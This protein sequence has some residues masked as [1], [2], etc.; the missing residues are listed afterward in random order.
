MKNINRIK[1]L[2]KNECA[3]YFPHQGSINHYCCKAD[4]TCLF[5]KGDDK[6]RCSYFETGVLPID[7]KLEHEYRKEHEL[8]LRGITAKTKIKCQRCGEY[9]TANSNRQ[10]YCD[11]CRKINNREKAK[12]RMSRMR[13]KG[14]DVTI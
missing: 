11:K 7:E 14:Y 2:I 6:T 8:S 12:H 9:I 4:G 10:Q 13:A 5:F 1:R 3:C